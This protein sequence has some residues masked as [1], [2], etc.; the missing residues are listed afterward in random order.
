MNISG[1]VAAFELDTQKLLL[2]IS[3]DTTF[4][5]IRKYPETLRDL[6]CFVPHRVTVAQV[7][8]C[9]VASGRG[10]VLGVE[11]F[12]RYVRAEEG[13]SLAF[14]IRLGREERALTGEE[15]DAVLADIVRGIES[16]VGGTIRMS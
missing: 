5:P 9:I 16:H 13:R 4:V 2:A 10:L 14:H 12:D 15:A 3:N 1:R 8:E 7:R 11:L 6:S